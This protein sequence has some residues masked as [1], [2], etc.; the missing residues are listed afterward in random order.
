MSE[1]LA[2]DDLPRFE[3][4]SLN[5]AQR[6]RWEAHLAECDRCKAALA[7]YQRNESYLGQVGWALE[8]PTDADGTVPIDPTG[9]GRRA[10]AIPDI[11]GYQIVRELHRG[12]QGVVYQAVQTSTKRKVAIKLLLDGRYAS[13][14]ARKRFEREIELVGQLKH[15][16]IIGIFHSGTTLDD[17]QF[18]VMDYVR[19]VPLRQFVR[20]KKL[21]LEDALK[22][23]GTVCDAVNYAH[24]RGVIHRDLKPSNIIVDTGGVP[25]VLD[26][27]LAKQLASPVESLVSVTGQVVGTLPYMSPE[28][29]RGNPDE[30]DI[31]TDVYALGVI[32]YEILTGH[33]PYPVVGQMAKVLKHIEQTPPTPPSRQWKVASGITKRSSKRLRPGQC[34][35]DDE[36]QTVVLKTLSKERER[37]YQSAGELGRDV[38]NYLSG[39]PIEARRDS[40]WYVLKKTLRRYKLPV[41]VVA[42]FVLLVS[43]ST[44]ALWI[45][46][47][48][49]TR[50]RMAEVQQRQVA[51]AA[52]R[53]QSR[54]RKEAEEARATAEEHRIL[55]EA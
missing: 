35:I 29:A 15:P 1:C 10:N 12:G 46:Y 20:D 19:G 2:H 44:L 34:P 9:K 16:N 27:G 32:L 4:D 48:N 21:G 11:E 33:Y 28:Q 14:S 39:Q 52:E 23:F 41:A 24:Q 49:Q 42:A 47:A 3:N 55:A 7:E 6:K 13:K 18:C 5:P 22:L 45:M 43:A 37:R 36:L 25:K 17:R 40:G 8:A 50:A 30:I 31:R 51:E 38:G 54:A 53:E 26:F